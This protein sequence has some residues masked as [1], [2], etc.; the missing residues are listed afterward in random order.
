MYGSV[1]NA[2]VSV[3]SP[4]E[5]YVRQRDNRNRT[6]YLF[7][8]FSKEGLFAIPKNTH[9]AESDVSKCLK[10]KDSVIFSRNSDGYYP[11]MLSGD[12]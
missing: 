11:H 6:G 12:G 3:C 10:S 7:K 2:D 1:L 9:S 4:P 8:I 5:G